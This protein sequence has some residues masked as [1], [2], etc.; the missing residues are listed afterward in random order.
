MFAAFSFPNTWI[1]EKGRKESV[2]RRKGRR[3]I[4]RCCLPP[5]F[6]VLQDPSGV[7]TPEIRVRPNGT[8]GKRKE[9]ERPPCV[10]EREEGVREKEEE[11]KSVESMDEMARSIPF[12]AKEKKI[13]TSH[14]KEEE[15][16]KER[17][18]NSFMTCMHSPTR[19]PFLPSSF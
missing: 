15:G 19:S 13:H 9:G 17:S 4:E 3:A 10:S 5:F 1:R 6:A 14:M 18:V 16:K 8:E 12:R 11:E 7:R 2:E